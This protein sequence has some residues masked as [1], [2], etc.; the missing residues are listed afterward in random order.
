MTAAAAKTLTVHEAWAKVMQDMGAVGKDNWNE[1]QKFKF[2]GIDQ[3]YGAMAGP[4]RKHGVF[5][6]PEVVDKH[7]DTFTS[8]NGK[9]HMHCV[10]TMKYTVYGPGG[11]SF[12]GGSIGEALDLYDKATSK[13]MSMALKYWLF[14]AA[15]IPL[16]EASVEDGDRHRP[17][18]EYESQDPV[19]PQEPRGAARRNQARPPVE[20]T[21]AAVRQATNALIA[22][23][24]EAM[25]NTIMKGMPTNVRQSTVPADLFTDAEGN[26]VTVS[27]LA[28]IV[29]EDMQRGAVGPVPDS[30][31]TGTKDT[32]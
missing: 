28:V 24:S 10:L 16:D 18:V 11:D 7:Y 19:P 14:G 20:D 29:K 32:L 5:L 30:W 9:T 6:V 27:R 4:M 13:A 22:C 3:L 2:R 25:L 17:E 15:M 8:G 1:Q 26:Q 23:Q 31:G 12:S 21:L